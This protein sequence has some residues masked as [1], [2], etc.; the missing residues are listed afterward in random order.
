MLLR[1]LA[2]SVCQ[3]HPASARKGDQALSTDVPTQFYRLPIIIT[4]SLW[5]S[6]WG[7]LWNRGAWNASPLPCCEWIRRMQK[8][9]CVCVCA[10]W[11]HCSLTVAR[12]NSWNLHTQSQ[13]W[14]TKNWIP[15]TSIIIIS[16]SQCLNHLYNSTQWPKWRKL[17]SRADITTS[18]PKGRKSTHGYTYHTCGDFWA[19]VLCRERGSDRS[20][21]NG[22]CF[23]WN[24]LQ[25]LY[26][27]KL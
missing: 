27:V 5:S 13:A 25:S 6:F 9:K 22:D 7:S 10:C 4:I 18:I 23:F 12:Q 17:Y 1:G 20:L 26:M 21:N 19:A 16:L 8:R 15:Y 24:F 3:G 11:K 14:S 2:S